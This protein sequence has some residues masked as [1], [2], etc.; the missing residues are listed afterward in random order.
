MM[1]EAQTPAESVTSEN[2]PERFQGWLATLPYDQPGYAAQLL[3]KELRRLHSASNIRTRLKL[4][5]P[6]VE[7]TERLLREANKRLAGCTLPMAPDVQQD[8]LDI[9]TL[10]RSLAQYYSD[11]ADEIASKWIG[12][13][14]AKPL[15]L[16]I[17]RSM[18]FQAQRLDLAYSVYARG[19]NSAWAELHR[20]YRVARNGGFATSAP[21]DL[22]VTAEQIYL[23]ALLLAFAEPTKL[24]PGELARVRDYVEQQW[25]FA[26]LLDADAGRPEEQDAQACFL[27]KPGEAR[28]GRSLVRAARL[29]VEPGDLIL[30]CTRLQTKLLGQLTGLERRIAPDRLGLPPLADD[31][32]YVAL[33]RNLQ[34]LWSA[35]PLRRHSRQNFKPRVDIVVGFDALITFLSGVAF[36]RRTAEA[37]QS[38]LALELSEWAIGN[39]SPGGFAVQYIG[40]N[41]GTVRVGEVVGLRPR[42]E[43]TVHICLMRRVVSN[44]LQSLELGLQKLAP[45][46]QAT[47][48]TVL[49]QGPKN[50]PLVQV[51][52]LQVIMLP[53]LPGQENAPAMIA[54]RDALT[55]GARI[56]ATEDGHQVTLQVS[57]PIEQC[58][59]CD[60]FALTAVAD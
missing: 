24:S 55:P 40:G 54:P 29:P 16:A 3:V 4:L 52:A 47:T 59:S 19:S 34:R 60:V 12:I 31:P 37:S 8:F 36:R 45:V 50:P 32:Q 13:G 57:K 2:D 41:A 30:R 7:P 22:D 38:A 21:L 27:I 14:F 28:A 15:L 48:I 10:L 18:Q 23:N 25:Q 39:E 58:A 9:N 6:A 11:V 26:E 1:P 56:L 42:D 20:L 44:D 46:T 5:E 53:R 49:D 17:V 35:P 43:S 33:L 51:L